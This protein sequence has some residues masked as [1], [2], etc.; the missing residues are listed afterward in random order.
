MR[1]LRLRRSLTARGRTAALC[2]SLAGCT[3]PPRGEIARAPDPL[4]HAPTPDADAGNISCSRLF[5]WENRQEATSPLV[6]PPGSNDGYATIAFY[7]QMSSLFRFTSAMFVLDGTIVHEALDEAEVKGKPIRAFAGPL[8]PGGHELNF[9]FKM[10]GHGEGAT[11]YHFEV[12]SS[13]KFTVHPGQPLDILV[14]AYE[15]G[16]SQTPF[17]ERPS[18]CI[19]ESPAPS[20]AGVGSQVDATST[21]APD[22]GVAAAAGTP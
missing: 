4:A 12:R 19:V 16:Q 11:A 5:H 14:F 7:Y 22:A 10:V 3:A 21:P 2:A 20:D 1:T 13:R 8:S 6:L 15:R 17:V 18:I 9:S